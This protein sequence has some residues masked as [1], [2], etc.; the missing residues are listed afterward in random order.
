MKR[1]DR[2]L[3][4]LED[5]QA[6]TEI[7]AEKMNSTADAYGETNPLFTDRSYAKSTKYRDLIAFPFIIE[8]GGWYA[9]QLDGRLGLAA[10]VRMGHY[11]CAGW[12]PELCNSS[13]SFTACLV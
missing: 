10:K 8:L 7:T 4:G 5:E 11:G 3:S 6:G 12:L 13:V 1:V 9:S 2:G